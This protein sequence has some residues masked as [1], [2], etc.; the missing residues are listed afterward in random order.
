LGAELEKMSACEIY[1]K[2]L[3]TI[4]ILERALKHPPIEYSKREIEKK[5]IMARQ[6]EKIYGTIVNTGH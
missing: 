5:L 6:L 1:S 3:E 2:L 4:E